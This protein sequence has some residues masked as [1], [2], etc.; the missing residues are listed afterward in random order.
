[1]ASLQ[2]QL[3]KAGLADTEKA[4]KIQKSKQKQTKAA[5]KS[6]KQV[7]DESKLAA[8]RA[9]IKQAERDRAL[10]IHKEQLAHEKAVSAQIIQLIENNRIDCQKGEQ[11]FNFVH[12]KIIKKIP[13]S[14][15][16]INQLSAGYVSIVGYTRNKQMIYEVV[17]TMVARKIEERDPKKVIHSADT[18]ILEN[19]DDDPYAEFIIPDD[20]VW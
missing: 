3:L 7:I 18:E 19:S 15:D 11:I 12:E 17:P 5:R 1:L 4:K 9:L 20:L 6:G 8:E 14:Q 2:D 13:V 16:I 10:N